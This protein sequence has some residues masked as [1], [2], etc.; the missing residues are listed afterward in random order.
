MASYPFL[1]FLL[2][3]ENMVAN[4]I[5]EQPYREAKNPSSKWLSG[6]KS[7]AEFCQI[8]ILYLLN[9]ARG[10]DAKPQFAS[11]ISSLHISN[12]PRTHSRRHATV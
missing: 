2:F 3:R 1:G 11:K 10:T 4:S 6:H 9:P 5:S 12:D 7:N 8:S